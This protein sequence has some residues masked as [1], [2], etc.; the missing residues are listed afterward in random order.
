[1]SETAAPMTPDTAGLG[2]RVLD[3]LFK[4][5]REEAWSGGRTYAK[6]IIREVREQ[7]A[8]DFEQLASN[9]N[10][11][12][13]EGSAAYSRWATNAADRIRHPERYEG[14]TANVEA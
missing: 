9:R 12:D 13:P 14:V 2:Q 3:L 11:D 4:W 6:E 7:I 1:M 8:S 10:P 5:R